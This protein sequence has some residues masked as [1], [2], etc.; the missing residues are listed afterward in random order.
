[1]IIN[2]FRIALRNILK[3][4][5]FSAINLIGMS[6]GMAASILILYFVLYE[7][8]FD[9]FHKNAKQI[10]RVELGTYRAGALENES[11][12]T[13]PAVGKSLIDNFPDVEAFTR[14]A[15]NP[16]KTIIIANDKSYKEEKAFI[17][18]PSF[19]EVF[20]FEL[21]QGSA[22]KMLS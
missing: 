3:S 18:D 17:V 19:L 9:R 14:V 1:M 8:S 21:I 7:T 4:K 11:A 6:V 12:L 16:G 13:S 22:D 2:Y 20:D 15:S 5:V 10:Y